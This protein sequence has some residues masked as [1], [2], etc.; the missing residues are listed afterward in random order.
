VGMAGAVLTVVTFH[1]LLF[2]WKG[3]KPAETL[4]VQ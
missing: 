1:I 2:L 4:V 3:L